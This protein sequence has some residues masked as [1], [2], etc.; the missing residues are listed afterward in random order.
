VRKT[1]LKKGQI[2]VHGW[3]GKKGGKHREYRTF[4]STGG[5]EYVVGIGRGNT[6]KTER[7]AAGTIKKFVER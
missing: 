5:R 4:F 1:I 3:G 6:A 2:P 7:K